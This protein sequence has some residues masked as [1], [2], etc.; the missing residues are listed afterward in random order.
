MFCVLN[1]GSAFPETR[2]VPISMISVPAPI[3][4]SSD[5]DDE[6]QLITPVLPNL[7]PNARSTAVANEADKVRRV[8]DAVTKK[9]FKA[10][11]LVTRWDII[12]RPLYNQIEAV[13]RE[14][15]DVKAAAVDL[16]R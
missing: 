12:N 6:E 11:V 1:A 10:L 8:R 15:E 13:Q 4:S 5:T 16:E 3:D 14:A 9:Y 2:M 7:P